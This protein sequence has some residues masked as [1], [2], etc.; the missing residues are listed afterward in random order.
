MFSSRSII[1]NITTSGLE[2]IFF[3]TFLYTNNQHLITDFHN[4]V[5]KFVFNGDGN[6]LFHNPSF[7]SDEK[8]SLKTVAMA[9]KWAQLIF[10]ASWDL[11]MAIPTQPFH[12]RLGWI[13]DIRNDQECEISLLCK[14]LSMLSLFL[15][16]FYCLLA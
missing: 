16:T 7:P 6:Y 13:A 3:L 15:L 1:S 2:L 14:H 5:L 12:A 11:R 4:T 8:G 10:S 9:L